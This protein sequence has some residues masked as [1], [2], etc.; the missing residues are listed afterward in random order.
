L[1]SLGRGNGRTDLDLFPLGHLSG[2]N[3]MAA[4]LLDK[5]RLASDL[6]PAVVQVC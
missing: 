1:K 5:S 4:K 6:V 2:S 3:P